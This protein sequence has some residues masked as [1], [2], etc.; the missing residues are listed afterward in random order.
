MAPPQLQEPARGRR[1]RVNLHVHRDCEEQKRN[2]GRNEARG[3]AQV[4][5][6][7]A[8]VDP[9]NKPESEAVAVI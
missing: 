9:S 8:V 6:Q 5:W 2:S 3:E 7:A 4:M 1:E